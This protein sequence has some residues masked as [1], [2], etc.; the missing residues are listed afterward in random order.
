MFF[1]N[2]KIHE[3]EKFTESQKQSLLTISRSYNY[4]KVKDDS[5]ED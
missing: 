5:R 4:S 1:E 3:L 2:L